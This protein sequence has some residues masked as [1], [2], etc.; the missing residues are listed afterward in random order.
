MAKLVEMIL[1]AL[2]QQRPCGSAAGL[3]RGDLR[4]QNISPGSH[5]SA[6]GAYLD[7][8]NRIALDGETE[9]DAERLPVATIFSM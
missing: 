1:G 5:R 6:H 2:I 3:R 8:L 4:P 7:L 9:V